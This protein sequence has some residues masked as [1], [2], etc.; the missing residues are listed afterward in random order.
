MAA[1]DVLDTRARQRGRRIFQIKD[2]QTLERW[3][4]NRRRTTEAKFASTPPMSETNA[5]DTKHLFSHESFLQT[6]ED[7]QLH[8]IRRLDW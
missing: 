3:S 8:R 5:A 4:R 1:K 2:T 6:S 7:G